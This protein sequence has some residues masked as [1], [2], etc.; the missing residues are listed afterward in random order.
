[1][2]LSRNLN[3]SSSYSNLA[4]LEVAGRRHGENLFISCWVKLS[5]SFKSPGKR[6]P[7]LAYFIW[8]NKRNMINQL[9]WLAL[10][11]TPSSSRVFLGIRSLQHMHLVSI[12]W[13]TGLFWAPE[14]CSACKVACRCHVGRVLKWVFSCS[15]CGFQTLHSISTIRRCFSW[16]TSPPPPTRP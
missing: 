6:L 4:R 12:V 15:R 2:K 16:G 8:G 5:Q 14:S 3:W 7:R 11:E 9:G 10:K 13:I 1:M